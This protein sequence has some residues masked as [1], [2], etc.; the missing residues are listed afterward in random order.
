M[1]F[2]FLMLRRP[3]RSTRTD[4]L[5]PYT[6]LC[7]SVGAAAAVP[8]RAPETLLE[9]RDVARHF[10]VSGPWLARTLAGAPRLTLKAVDGVSFSIRRGE[11]LSLV[12][13]SGC[14]KTTVARL[15]V[16]LYRQIGRAHV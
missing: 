13:E 2:C 9:V 12:G 8:A 1:S 4:T 6:T 16:G 15:I 7:R 3:P 5:F 14:G 11:T 10:E